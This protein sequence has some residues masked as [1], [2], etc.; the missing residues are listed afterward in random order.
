MAAKKDAALIP[1]DN[2]LYKMAFR[3]FRCFSASLCDCKKT[4]YIAER[5]RRYKIIQKKIYHI[6]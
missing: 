3:I 6:K 1:Y 5:Y 4:K 2:R